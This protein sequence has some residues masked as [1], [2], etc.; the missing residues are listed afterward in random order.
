MH[1]EIKMW[2]DIINICVQPI[3]KDSTVPSIEEL[4]KELENTIVIWNELKKMIY[5]RYEHEHSEYSAV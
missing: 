1:R 5:E 2:D 4:M 3:S